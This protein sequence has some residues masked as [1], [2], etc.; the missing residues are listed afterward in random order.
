M[1][2][3]IAALAEKLHADLTV[4][5]PEL[6]L[7]RGVADEFAKRGMALLGP[8]RAA[9][10]LEGSKIFA[11]EFMQRHAIPTAA[12]IGVFTTARKC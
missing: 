9:A 1:W 12:T 8:T 10:E 11:K 5:G 7:V 6:P 4:I 3:P 2:K